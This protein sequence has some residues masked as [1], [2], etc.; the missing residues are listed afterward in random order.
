MNHVNNRLRLA[1]AKRSLSQLCLL[2]SSNS[3]ADNHNQHRNNVHNNQLGSTLYIWP[4]ERACAEDAA[5]ALR[6]RTEGARRRELCAQK[7]TISVMSAVLRAW[8]GSLVWWLGGGGGAI[9]RICHRRLTNANAKHNP[10]AVRIKWTKWRRRHSQTE[11]PVGG[12]S[13][14]DN[15]TRTPRNTLT[16]AGGRA[17]TYEREERRWS[18]V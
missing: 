1:L 9:R 17:R 8:A 7:G 18:L 14:A 13:R 15:N 3:S 4:R 10:K 12:A 2:R 5:T 11:K 16:H 6:M